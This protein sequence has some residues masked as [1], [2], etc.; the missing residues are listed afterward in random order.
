MGYNRRLA[1]TSRPGRL[2]GK[3]APIFTATRSRIITPV[4]AALAGLLLGLAFLL[5]ILSAATAQ[6]NLADQWGRTG[7]DDGQ[8]L[9]IGGID[10][11][12][13]GNVYAVDVVS[14]RIQKFTAAGAFV[15]AW[16]G[17][18]TGDGRF[19]GLQDVAVDFAGNIYGLDLVGNQV[20]RLAP[21][22]SFVTSWEVIGATEVIS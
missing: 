5:P 10:V 13:G 19:V 11:D 21:D 17:Q 1:Q 15:A 4:A 16:G 9:R 8:F 12:A 20:Q 6:Y 3:E 18:G 22:G 14:G 7:S 2:E